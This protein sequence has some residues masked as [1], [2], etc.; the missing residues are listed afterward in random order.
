MRERLIAARNG[1]KQEYGREK[2]E[3]N[4]FHGILLLYD[5]YWFYYTTG[6]CFCQ[7]SKRAMDCGIEEKVFCEKVLANVERICYHTVVVKTTHFYMHP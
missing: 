3:E 4:S 1:G 2:C 5:V 7:G 6:C